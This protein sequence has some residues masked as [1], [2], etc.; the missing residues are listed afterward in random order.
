[1]E[2]VEQQCSMELFKRLEV[3]HAYECSI[4]K[5]LEFR[6][7]LN[8]AISTLIDIAEDERRRI[9]CLQMANAN[10]LTEDAWR[11]EG[12]AVAPEIAEA[13]RTCTVTVPRGMMAL[14]SEHQPTGT[15][16]E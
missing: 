7:N 14:L 5:C 13:R 15:T 3:L 1:M 12:L 8:A 2:T 11:K 6:E 16:K 10:A 4:A 9:V